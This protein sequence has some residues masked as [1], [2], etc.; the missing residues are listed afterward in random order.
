MWAIGN[1]FPECAALLLSEGA[2]VHAMDSSLRG[3]LHRA[4]S[5]TAVE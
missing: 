5:S 2:S 3:A 4:V 1:G